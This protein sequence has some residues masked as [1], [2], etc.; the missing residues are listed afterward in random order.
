MTEPTKPKPNRFA[1][2][3]SYDFQ[4]FTGTL[5]G[6]IDKANHG[7]RRLRSQE[8]YFGRRSKACTPTRSSRFM[9]TKVP[10]CASAI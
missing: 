6:T 8:N 1:F 2:R 4:T 10:S 7:P 3:F 5:R 9:S